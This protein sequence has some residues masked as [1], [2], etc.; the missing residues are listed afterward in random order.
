MENN[1]KYL[2]ISHRRFS[3]NLIEKKMRADLHVT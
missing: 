3:Q 1:S 2:L